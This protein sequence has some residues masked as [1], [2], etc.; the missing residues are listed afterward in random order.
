MG[1]GVHLFWITSRAAGISALLLASAS[2]SVGLTMSLRKR[3]RGPDLRTVHE[4]LSLATIAAIGLHGVALLADPWLRP[5]IAGV[6]LPFQIGYRPV[7][8]AAGILA[9]YGL[10]ALGLGYYARG[11]IGP[12]RW[13]R[14]HRWTALFWLLAV[15]HGFT[16]GSD[17]TAPW[18][19]LSVGL[20]AAP[21]AVLLARR[22]GGGPRGASESPAMPDSLGF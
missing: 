17:A 16:A 3:G 2:V 9:A 19:F 6:L 20:V 5:G 15:A 1:S 7:A 13:K 10:V 8:V 18:F 14:L 12:A 11:R 21:G 4:A 22:L